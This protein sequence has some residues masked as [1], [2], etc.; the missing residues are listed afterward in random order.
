ME[1]KQ[2]E[3]EI[4][5][6]AGDDDLVAVTE[7]WWDSSHGWNVVMDGYVFL[8]EDRPAR[9]GGGV[10]LYVREQLE[11]IEYCPGVDEDA[12]QVESMQ[13]G[14][15]GQAGMRGTVV[16]VCYRPLDQN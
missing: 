14:I 2:E 13:V 15:K 4:C 5:D 11:R 8:W 6:Q 1:N 12:E 3:L 7:T 9:Q 16:G 10:A